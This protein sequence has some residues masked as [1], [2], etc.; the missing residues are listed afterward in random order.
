MNE[1]LPF[2][3]RGLSIVLSVHSVKVLR[4]CCVALG[5]YVD[6]F[7][8]ISFNIPLWCSLGMFGRSDEAEL[9]SVAPIKPKK[10]VSSCSAAKPEPMGLA[11][12]WARFKQNS[13]AASDTAT[14]TQAPANREEPSGA[15]DTPEGASEEAARAELPSKSPQHSKERKSFGDN[16]VAVPLSERW[17]LVYSAKS[18]QQLRA[19]LTALKG[20]V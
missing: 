14:A 4:L 7:Y 5:V 17:T 16:F 6:F 13:V 12:G 3:C 15:G 18:L 2:L 19:A 10:S 8:S 9:R 11:D 20:L 1:L